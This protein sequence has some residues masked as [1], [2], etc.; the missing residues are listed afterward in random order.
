MLNQS[1]DSKRSKVESAP[2]CWSAVFRDERCEQTKNRAQTLRGAVQLYWKWPLHTLSHILENTIETQLTERFENEC[3]PLTACYN[4]HIFSHRAVYFIGH[5]PTRLTT[6]IRNLWRN[7]SCQGQS[8]LWPTP[9]FRWLCVSVCMFIYIFWMLD[10]PLH[11]SSTDHF[12]CLSRISNGQFFG[13]YKGN[14]ASEKPSPDNHGPQR[15][16]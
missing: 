3:L 10:V 13:K 6:S 2:Q 16:S 7:H 1:V 11:L 15:C 12:D 9:D 14:A 8:L 4:R 5:V